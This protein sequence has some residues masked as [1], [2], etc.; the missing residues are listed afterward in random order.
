M[1]LKRDFVCK[2]GAPK[3]VSHCYVTTGSAL[4]RRSFVAPTVMALL[5][6]L[7]PVLA[8]VVCLLIGYMLVKSRD[9]ESTPRLPGQAAK[10]ESRPWV[11]QHLQDGTEHAQPEEGKKPFS[12]TSDSFQIISD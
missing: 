3:N 9:A 8:L 4:W 10:V 5:S 7:T 2:R 12:F 6:F 1:Y 11:D